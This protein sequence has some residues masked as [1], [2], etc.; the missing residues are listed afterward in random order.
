MEPVPRRLFDND[1]RRL[2]T[3]LATATGYLKELHDLMAAHARGEH[4]EGHRR[5]HVPSAV[6]LGLID[7]SPSAVAVAR[8]TFLLEWQDDASLGDADHYWN[9]PLFKTADRWISARQHR[10]SARPIRRSTAADDTVSK[11][12]NSAAQSS[13]PR[14]R[15]SPI[16]YGFTALKPWIIKRA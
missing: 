4:E 3:K 6:M 10:N 5:G 12:V 8:E 14:I 16:Q 9:S 13:P 7:G 1:F 11:A 2:R 15:P